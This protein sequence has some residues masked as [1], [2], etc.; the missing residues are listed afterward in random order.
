[1]KFLKNV[2]KNVIKFYVWK[3]ISGFSFIY[4]LQAI[5]LLTKGITAAELAI[6]ASITAITTTITEIPTGY[7]ADKFSRKLSISL[8][9]FIQ[10]IAYIVIILSNNLFT[11]IPIGILLGLGNSL[12]SGSVESLLYDLL[13][14]SNDEKSY[15][16]INS[17]GSA[18]ETITG[19]IATFLGPIIYVINHESPFILT[20]VV[21]LILSLFVYTIDEA[22]SDAEE[23]ERNLSALDGIKNILKNKAVLIITLADTILLVMVNLFY[24]VLNF[25]KL[26][27]LGFP[28]EFLG[29]LDVL[30]L[31]L[32]TL[33]LLIV[34]KLVLKQLKN[35]FFI[36]SIATIVIFSLYYFTSNLIGAIVFGILFDVVWSARKQVMPTITNEYFS[37]KNRAT[38]ISSM[39]FLSNLGASILV[40]VTLQ[41]FNQNSLFVFLPV[42][43]IFGLFLIYPSD[44]K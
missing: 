24:Q 2:P 10:G 22:K 6:F 25:P 4:S 23:V 34:S 9:F 26:E 27:R 40:P 19:V 3:L 36:Y 41:L 1:M 31:V 17:R 18:I 15:L 12:L 16:K 42:V 5:Y 32:M 30:N 8:G 29:S 20:G 21:L 7:I 13:K 11:L 39:S 14:S 38:S 44:Q 43:L 33:M 35:T 28:I 37:S